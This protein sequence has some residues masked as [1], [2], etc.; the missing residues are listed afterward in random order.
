ME[1]VAFSLRMLLRRMAGEVRE[2]VCAGG[3]ASSDTWL[4]IIADA[5]GLRASRAPE[6]HSA[7]GACV[8]AARAAGYG[9]PPPEPGRLFE[10]R[11]SDGMERAYERFSR[12]EKVPGGA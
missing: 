11:R 10:P 1:G 8:L 2:L 3:G 7:V 9:L 12:A 6:L 4:Q 5:T